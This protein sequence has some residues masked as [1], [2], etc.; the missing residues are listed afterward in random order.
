MIFITKTFE[1][2]AIFQILN[3]FFFNLEIL[4]ILKLSSF[5]HLYLF[6]FKF[7]LF[8]VYYF[9]FFDI[10]QPEWGMYFIFQNSNFI[11]FII[12]NNHYQHY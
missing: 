9:Y 1:N 7:K 10:Y 6:L 8:Y 4:E 12:K 2:F 5:F 11:Q 3:E